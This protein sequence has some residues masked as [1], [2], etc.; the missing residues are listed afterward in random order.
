MSEILFEATRERTASTLRY[1]AD[2]LGVPHET[3][4]GLNGETEWEQQRADHFAAWAFR[5]AYKRSC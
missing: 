5:R 3:L 2:I 1:V 4:I